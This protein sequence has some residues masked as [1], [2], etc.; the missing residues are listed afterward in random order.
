MAQD[1]ENRETNQQISLKINMARYTGPKQRLQ[2]HIGEDL[3]LKT[4]ALK[5]A[6][7][8][9]VKPGQ[10]GH[11]RTRKLSDYGLQLLAKQRVKFIYGVLE[12]QL[13]RLYTQA[14]RSSQGTGKA[15]LIN[16]ERRLDNVVYRLGWAPTRAC[17]RQLVGHNHVLVNNKK[18]NIPSYQVKMG[19]V[20]SLKKKTT[21]IPTIASLL[22]DDNFAVPEWMERKHN[23]AKIVRL[24]ERNEIS[25]KIEEQLIVEFYSR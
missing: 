5:T 2:R 14:A 10:H 7:R 6:K 12:K 3:A 11:K 4:N 22:G 20:I 17:A 21:S 25:E 23:V 9:N 24:P 8:I 19:D 18:M 13:K 16:L 1:Q 15:L